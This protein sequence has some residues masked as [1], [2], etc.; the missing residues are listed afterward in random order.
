MNIDESSGVSTAKVSAPRQ[1]YLR[2]MLID[3]VKYNCCG[4]SVIVSLYNFPYGHSLDFSI[5]L[6][7]YLCV[8]QSYCNCLL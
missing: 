7:I 2:A 8:V 6:I 5:L 3:D 1:L 4:L